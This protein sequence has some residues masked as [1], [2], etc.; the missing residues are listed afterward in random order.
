MEQQ[1]FRTQADIFRERV[2]IGAAVGLIVGLLLGWFV[3]GWWI[4][5]V[6]WVDAEP[7][8]LHP[9]WQNHYVAMVADSYLVTGDAQIARD[10]LKG[11]GEETLERVFGDVEATFERQGAARQAQAVRQ[12][13][14]Q[15]GIS[16][17][18][19][20]TPA[21]AEVAEG[22]EAAVETTVPET[23]ASAVREGGTRSVWQVL[24]LALVIMVA[25]VAGVGGIMW[26]QRRS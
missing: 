18:P 16:I 19:P 24:L 9:D 6:Q 21:A 8:D 3:L 5:P 23:S 4:A 17:V 1:E 7:G 14:D 12:L 26:F 22:E 25:I 20:G 13:A 2:Q 15:M 11:F 10:R